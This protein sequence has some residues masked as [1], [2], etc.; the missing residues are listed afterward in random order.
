MAT[1][2]KLSN[3]DYS[4][5][6]I[7]YNC[8]LRCSLSKIHTAP[9]FHIYIFSLK[10]TEYTITSQRL[11]YGINTCFKRTPIISSK[12]AITI[13]EHCEMKFYMTF[14]NVRVISLPKH[15]S[16][17]IT[18]VVKIMSISHNARFSKHVI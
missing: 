6:K 4:G 13:P 10:S 11:T 15:G 16:V 2:I 9:L 14:T 8:S 5:F 7:K 1:D 12:V 18:A 3:T 17:G